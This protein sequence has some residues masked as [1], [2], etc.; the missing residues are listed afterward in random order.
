[1]TKP[2][3]HVFSALYDPLLWVGERT[4]MAKRRRDLLSEANGRVLELGAGTGLRGAAVLGRD[5]A[6]LALQRRLRQPQRRAP[7][8][9]VDHA[10][11][12]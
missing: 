2:W 6:V 7:V 3:E 12:K 5:D 11:G 1:M 10:I 9:H 8:I 4:G